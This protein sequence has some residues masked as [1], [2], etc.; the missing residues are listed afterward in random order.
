MTQ[1]DYITLGLPAA[2]DAA[3]IDPVLDAGR[4]RPEARF[5]MRATTIAKYAIVGIMMS[6]KVLG[7]EL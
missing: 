2:E 4:K 5:A 6:R 1:H 7:N 3:E